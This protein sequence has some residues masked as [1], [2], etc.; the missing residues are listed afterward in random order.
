MEDA[1]GREAPVQRF[2]D[3]IAG[4]FAYTIM[5]LSGVTFSFWCATLAT[6]RFQKVLISENPCTRSIEKDC[7]V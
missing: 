6:S 7:V 4:P 3:K 1:Q 5:A 2:A